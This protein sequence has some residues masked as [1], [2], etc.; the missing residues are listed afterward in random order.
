MKFLWKITLLLI[1][2]LLPGVLS[3]RTIWEHE[4]W[5]GT[6]EKAVFSADASRVAC[7]MT[8]GRILVR[9]MD[10]GEVLLMQ[11]ATPNS[12]TQIDI[13]SDGQRVA[14]GDV[15]GM[16]RSW[17]SEGGVVSLNAGEMALTGLALSPDGTK[18]SYMGNGVQFGMRNT[19][20]LKSIDLRSLY[21][22]QV[23]A[24]A[25]DSTGDLILAGDH[26]GRVVRVKRSTGSKLSKT[27]SS[28]GIRGALFLSGGPA[29]GVVWDDSGNLLF[30][31]S[32]LL[33]TASVQ[34]GEVSVSC[35]IEDGA[36]DRLIVATSGG[37][38]V[39]VDRTRLQLLD[40][41]LA[42]LD[43]PAVG[44]GIQGD[45]GII[46]MDQ[47]GTTWNITTDTVQVAA[48]PAFSGQ[49]LRGDISI[50]AGIA[51][52]ITTE[53]G[54]VSRL[55]DGDSQE[56]DPGA[57]GILLDV[58]I[59][60][61]REGD[62]PVQ[63]VLD[64]ETLVLRITG[65]CLQEDIIV[66]EWTPT[67]IASGVWRNQIALMSLD[68]SVILLEEGAEG[69]NEV[70]SE[71]A[72]PGTF[73]DDIAFVDNDSDFLRMEQSVENSFPAMDGPFLM[74]ISPA[75][76]MQLSSIE[77]DPVFFAYPDLLPSPQGGMDTGLFGIIQAMSEPWILH[78][79][80]GWG[81]FVPNSVTSW[82]W[83]QNEGWLASAGSYS[84]FLYS[85]ST[86]DWLYTLVSKQASNWVYDY[87][88]GEWRV[89]AGGY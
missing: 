47:S 75:R 61:G 31:D 46:A 32:G 36:R 37:L 57:S 14:W 41:A 71:D 33:V 43:Q 34:L 4:A 27:L 51:S 76:G 2:V 13:S 53:G 35:V 70:L 86:E 49:T 56:I 62:C 69:F 10:T 65:P 68:G 52:F 38:V 82:Y 58:A 84:P 73:W 19:S 63:L 80:F 30:V 72:L 59:Y 16:L 78:R 22:E 5:N 11:S 23:H 12:I 60:H 55:S 50:R 21:I 45:G 85:D 42:M 25:T 83:F 81:Y 44:L 24:L 26:S 1:P 15:S 7:A 74:E 17:S 28:E 79:E 6:I 20:D 54:W 64:R 48:A 8:D 29:E 18:V 67:R 3:A 77:T 88:L 39:A 89:F 66:E 9:D 87:S 40:P